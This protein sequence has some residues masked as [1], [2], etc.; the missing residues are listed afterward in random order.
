MKILKN[1]KD[2]EFDRLTVLKEVESRGKHRI[3]L[4]R[5]ACG[6]ET[7]KYQSNLVSGQS[8]SCG[9]LRK[10][11]SVEA[12]TKH[13]MTDSVEYECWCQMIRRCYN[14][15]NKSYHNYGGRGIYVCQRWRKSF[16][17]FYEDMGQR[18]F[19]R[20][21]LDRIDVEGHYCLENC[22][23]ATQRRQCC[24]KR[25]NDNGLPI[26]CVVKQSG[27]FQS[28]IRVG[29]KRRCLGTFLH[30]EEAAKAYDD[31]CEEFGDGRP[32]QENGWY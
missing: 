15:K 19:K 4:C 12:N 1:L 14:K 32:N 27:R 8:R 11:R 16:E 20:Y 30:I 31:K 22:R 28:C 24:N 18:P 2:Q 21:S 17:N 5:C 23:W 29:K 25:E 13:G 3:W 26:G 10:E 7:E 9:C 6:N